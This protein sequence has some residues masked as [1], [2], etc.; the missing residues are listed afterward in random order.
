MIRI[1]KKFTFVSFLFL[2]SFFIRSIFIYTIPLS[3]DEASLGYNAYSILKTARDEY[4]NFLPLTLNSFGDYKSILYVYLC[5][6][7]I[8]LLGLTEFSI[9]L[10]SI[11]CG[12]LLPLILYFLIKKINPKA[13]KTAVISS[14]IMATNPYNIFFSRGA[15]ETNLLTFE[16][17]LGS[18]FFYNFLNSSKTKFLFLS[19]LI[20]SLSFYTYQLG[21]MTSLLI[22]M[23]LILV[24]LRSLKIKSFLVYFI[25]PLFFL[26]LPLFY[27]SFFNHNSNF[28]KK[29]NLFSYHR[30]KNE[31][32]IIIKETSLFDYQ[33]FHNQTIFFVRN[34]LLRY[35]NHFSPRFLI[36]EG[37]WQNPS[38]S[39]PY[40]GVILYPSLFFFIIGLFFTLSKPKLDNINIFFLLW[41]L[42]AP[43]PSALTQ[44]LVQSNLAMPLSIPLVYFISYGIIVFFNKYK[45]LL[46]KI[47]VVLIYL[48]SFYYY[49]DL[50]LHHLIIKS[51]YDFFYGHKQAMQY[52]IKNQ[53]KYKKII[54]SNFYGQPYIFYL[55]YSHYPPYQYQQ[56]VQTNINNLDTKPFSSIQKI[57][58]Q[59]PNFETIF[60]NPNTLA[61]FS[62]EEIYRQGIDKNP[63]FYRFIPLS[64]IGN[65]STFYA[66]ENP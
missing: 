6:P 34:F 14:L 4:G 41:L 40:I 48:L 9:R 7:F 36:F 65:I 25:L 26:A 27:N 1:F 55:F 53:S 52:L 22:I 10:P 29:I 61:I 37:D 60:E 17:V 62:Q 64:P 15:W 43:I 59:T 16:L 39:V 42:V 58:F 32:Q 8:Y 54:F 46:L 30:L 49:S 23:I 19:S 38:N 44:S 47:G 3:S 33:I 21:M 5:L 28:L 13:H 2:I 12:S 11:I 57:S 66:Y 35:F 63:L 45:S 31:T 20:F 24:N 50:Y 51:P 18:F 56:T